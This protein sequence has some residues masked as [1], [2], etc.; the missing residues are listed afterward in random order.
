MTVR[1]FAADL[2]RAVG[3]AIDGRARRGLAE[4]DARA[5]AALSVAHKTLA[6][7]DAALSEA[8]DAAVA[9]DALADMLRESV[10]V[11]LGWATDARRGGAEVD[12]STLTAAPLRL[13]TARKLLASVRGTGEP[14]EEARRREVLLLVAEGRHVAARAVREFARAAAAC[15]LPAPPAADAVR[16]AAEAASRSRPV[17]AE[18][19]WWEEPVDFPWLRGWP[20]Y[21]PTGGAGVFPDLSLLP[22]GWS[23][24]TVK[25][26]DVLFVAAGRAPSPSA[27]ATPEVV[28]GCRDTSAGRAAAR[29]LLLEAAARPSEGA[30]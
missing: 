17:P 24:E 30:P 7:A 12:D 15:P 13:A 8:R 9:R 6:Q 27:A 21:Q 14:D 25:R 18:D 19:A 22:L 1:D 4:V 28:V 11:A 10:E 23:F 29:A 16:A 20:S 5:D 2:L 26:G 3:D